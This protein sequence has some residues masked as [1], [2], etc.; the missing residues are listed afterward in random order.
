MKTLRKF[1]ILFALLWA[2]LLVGA[3][4]S[5]ITLQTSPKMREETKFLVFC[6][7]RAHF[8]KTAIQDLDLREF[9]R[10]YMSNL[11]FMRLFF[12]AEDLQHYQDLFAP[13]ADIMLHQGT[14]LPAFTIYDRFLERAKSRLAWIKERI[15]K[16][17]DLS[18]KESF[19]PD[20]SKQ[21]W[22]AS[23]ASADALWEKRLTFDIEN[24]ILSYDKPKKEKDKSDDKLADKAAAKKD[25]AK[26]MTFDEKVEKA[27]AEV[28]KRYEKIVE[29]AEKSDAMEIQE[30]YLHT[31]CSMYDPHSEFMSEYFLEEFDISIRNSLVGIGA[32][33][34]DKDGYCTINELMAGGPAEKSKKIKTG[35]KIVAVSDANGEMVDVIGMKL[36]KVVKMIRGDK[37]TTVRLKI[38]PANNTSAAYEISLVRDEIKLTTKL[39]KAAVYQIPYRDR[40]IPIGV[41]DLPAFYGENETHGAKGFSTTKN[42]E[43]L[44][45][46]LKAQNVK[47]VIL[48]IRRN[49]GGFLNEAIDLAGLF[50][51]KGPVVQTKDTAGRQNVL[52][53]ENPKVVWQ[54]PLIVLVSKLSASS[55]EILAGALKDHKRAIIVGDK[56][57]FGKGTVQTVYNLSNFEPEL[58]SAAKITVQKWYAPNG[59]SIQLKG[60]ESDISFPSIYDDMKIDEASKDNAMKW[61]SIKSVD[62][63]EVYNYGINAANA[64]DLIAKLRFESEKRRQNSNEFK[65]YQ[66]R[67]DWF[68]QKQKQKSYSLDINARKSQMEKDQAFLDENE[69]REKEFVKTNYTF[70]EILL[71]SAKELEKDT[72]KK[73][74]KLDDDLNEL[75]ALE[76][77]D[78]PEFDV[79]M[80][81]SL[82]IM[83]DWI[84]E[85]ESQNSQAKTK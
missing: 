13:T 68:K 5:P 48:D 73:K 67:V 46:K 10:E 29:N 44:L 85:I 63:G 33:L 32:V 30:I 83:C 53:D 25:D 35:D 8:D 79:Q 4:Q 24:Q 45:L 26:P 41:I 21:D 76:D 39:A 31:L 28:L 19:T 34:Q 82:H 70:T 14:M 61:D 36:R 54:G 16:P 71:D 11:D 15:K 62:V 77:D 80:R 78:A 7:E 50:I 60:I 55:S 40:T 2:A 57:T 59:E 74:K 72:P 75:D 38:E 42:V 69:K 1:L 17:I 12:L 81:E 84:S 9:V 6:M 47:G 49:G 52:S 51:K 22:P 43:E 65:F 66:E 37:N 27:K 3:A 58:K 64:G 20:R 56:N 18:N 23:T